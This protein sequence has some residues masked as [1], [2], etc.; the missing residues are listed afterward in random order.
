LTDV[1]D[2]ISFSSEN[3]TKAGD[4]WETDLGEDNRMERYLNSYIKEL[5]DKFPET[6][7]VLDTH[8]IGCAPCSVGTCLLKDVVDIHGLAREDEKKLLTEIAAII[9]P[10]KKVE[11]P[12]REGGKEKRGGEIAYSPPMKRLVNEHELIK[13]WIKMIPTISEKYVT[14]DP[15]MEE[16]V[17]RGVD[18]I[19]S[20]ADRFHHAKE[21]KILF[22]YFDQDLDIV[23][24]MLTDH[25]TGRGHVKEIV[26]G[27]EG[28]DG[29][30]V[31]THLRAY[32]DL[33]TDHIRK[34][35]EILYP[36]MDRYLTT[37]QVGELYTKFLEVDGIAGGTEDYYTRFVEETEKRF[38]HKEEM[39]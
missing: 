11:I 5:I 22:A 29:E 27:I 39:I 33:L 30:K 18:F 3:L 25:E 34:E 38:I 1:N 19:R 21:E 12:L 36:W 17:T 9:Y 24:A 6:A 14:G 31:T 2:R 32:G 16:L 26:K 7:E 28:G 4:Q 8:G 20:Y 10:G 37:S 35:D 13:R 23:K 15:R